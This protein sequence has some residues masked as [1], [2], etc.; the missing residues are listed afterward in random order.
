MIEPKTTI[1]DLYRIKDF[2]S[3]RTAYVRLDKNERT[4]PFPDWA[5][6]EMLDRISPESLTMYPNQ[7]PLYGR[8]SSFWQLDERFFLLT[9]GSDAAIK[10]IFETYVAPGD[11][12]LF[13]DP[14]YAMVEV[15]AGMFAARKVKVGF[16]PDLQLRF[17]ALVASITDRTR[18][19]F[20]ANPNQPT[21]TILDDEQI[22]YLLEETY[23]TNTLIV[24]DEAYQPFSG[25]ESVIRW[26][27]KHPHLIITQTFSKGAG[28]AAVRLG[29]ICTDPRNINSLYKVKTHA[30]I[31]L[32]AIKFGE[33]LLDHYDLVEEYVQS[34][35]ASKAL[36]EEEMRKLEVE[37]LKGYANFVHLRF[38]DG[39]CLQSVANE[40]K[41]RGY[42]VRISGDGMPAVI[43]RC[44]RITVGPVEQ[45]REF[46]SVFKEVIATLAARQAA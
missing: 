31:N 37:V 18:A 3:D 4:T 19:V 17:D 28:L 22:E 38:P 23:R 25:Q 20:I 1:K 42:L 15:Y 14:T 46:L 26:V 2:G 6:K 33:Y 10:T 8:L 9:P 39:V 30:D 45:M 36:I 12:V 41:K 7:A 40:L 5:L 21:G 32:F 35:K 27:Q 43:E 13:L 34:V 11:E 29:F 24:F 16:S 44:I